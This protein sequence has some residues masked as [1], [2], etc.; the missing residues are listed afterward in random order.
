VKKIAGVMTDRSIRPD[1]AANASNNSAIVAISQAPN[2]QFLL[3]GDS[4]R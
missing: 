1:A 3:C 2:S 4:Q